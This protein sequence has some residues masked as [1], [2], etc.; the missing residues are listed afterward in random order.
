MEAKIYLNGSSTSKITISPNFSKNSTQ[1]VVVSVIPTAA[2][3]QA[4]NGNLKLL[5]SV[6][7]CEKVTSDMNSVESSKPKVVPARLTS[8]PT[9][10]KQQSVP[11]SCLL[12]HTRNQGWRRKRQK[13]GCCIFSSSRTHT[14]FTIATFSICLGQCKHIQG[15]P[16]LASRPKRL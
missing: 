13:E 3:I 6:R 2:P 15:K 12:D 1:S 4:T 9:V 8:K 16:K 5:P 14:S 10:P 7:D 11:T